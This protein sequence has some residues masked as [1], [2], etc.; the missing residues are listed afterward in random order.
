MREAFGCLEQDVGRAL[1]QVSGLQD[2]VDAGFREELP[3]PI[4]HPA[5]QLPGR[6][7]RVDQGRLDHLLPHPIRD[8]VPDGPGAWLSVFQGLRP[9]FQVALVPGVEGRAR[10]PDLGQGTPHRERRALHQADQ[11]ELLCSADPHAS[12]SGESEPVT[13]FLSSRFSSSVSATNSFSRAFSLR[14]SETSLELASRCVSPRRRFFPAS[15]NSLLH[16]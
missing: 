15:R 7:R 6:E 16:L 5:G 11:L 14:R 13:L 2:P 4:R 1:D 10:Q 3:L 12:S 8:P 9:A